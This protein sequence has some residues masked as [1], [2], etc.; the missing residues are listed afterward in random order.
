MSNLERA[1]QADARERAEQRAIDTMQADEVVQRLRAIVDAFNAA[2]EGL[3]ASLEG[4]T[5]RVSQLSAALRMSSGRL[6]STGRAGQSS[7]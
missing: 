2:T 5:G 1:A 4:R 7:G 6:N 3:K